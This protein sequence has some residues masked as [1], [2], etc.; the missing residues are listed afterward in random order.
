MSSNMYGGEDECD[1]FNVRI[2]WPNNLRAVK[3]DI[4]RCTCVMGIFK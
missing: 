3:A 2:Y 1:M 4:L